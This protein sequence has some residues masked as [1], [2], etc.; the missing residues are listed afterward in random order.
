MRTGLIA[1]KVGM[2]MF[3]QQSGEVIPVTLLHVDSCHVLGS[4][5]SG[6]KIKLEVGA[7]DKLASRVSKPLKGFFAKKK[8]SPKQKIVEFVVSEDA[9]VDAGVELKANHF[10]EGQVIDVTGTSQGKGFA[11]VMKRHNFSGLRASHGVS[12]S[13]RSHGSTGQCQDPG[14][15]FKGKKMAGHMGAKRVTKQNIQIIKIDLDSNI[16]AV[17]GSVPGHKGGFLI[18]KDAVKRAM[19]SE[20]PYPCF[21]EKKQE[22]T[23][24]SGD[25]QNKVSESEA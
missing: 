21:V 5:K 4:K 11:G 19:P 25:N 17:K 14:K 18:L 15:V 3:Y 6:N 2:S 23:E 22:A 16:I 13:H 20:A 12:I 8:V 7:V 9:V 1:K 24:V 10:V